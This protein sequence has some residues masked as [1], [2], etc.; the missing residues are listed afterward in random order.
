MKVE[1]NERISRRGGCDLAS[2]G[3]DADGV[4]YFASAY[5]ASLLTAV[6]E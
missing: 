6:Q 1:S 3:A 4:K 5:F 2:G